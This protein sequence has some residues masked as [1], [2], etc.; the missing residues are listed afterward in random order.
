[1][2][3]GERPSAPGGKAPPQGTWAS[4]VPRLGPFAHHTWALL[5]TRVQ[6]WAGN[7]RAGWPRRRAGRAASSRRGVRGRAFYS[8]L[9]ASVWVTY[10]ECGPTLAQ[11]RMAGRR[12]PSRDTQEASQSDPEAQARRAEV[13]I[14]PISFAAHAG[15]PRH[16][17]VFSITPRRVRRCSRTPQALKLNL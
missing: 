16:T 5:P 12:I 2:P 11:S 4:H 7:S 17:Y 10:P 13:R 15:H 9:E 14:L 8:E 1:V 6:N 3:P